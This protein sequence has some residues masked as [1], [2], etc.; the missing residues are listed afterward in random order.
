MELKRSPRFNRVFNRPSPWFFCFF[1]IQLLLFFLFTSLDH[2]E[3]SGFS[4][5]TEFFYFFFLQLQPCVSLS[6]FVELFGLFFMVCFGLV[7]F[8]QAF[9]NCTSSFTGVDQVLPGFTGFYLF[10][11]SFTRFYWVLLGFTGFYWVLPSFTGFYWVLPSFLRVL[12]EFT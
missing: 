6:C 8:D 11:L 10:W 4:C 1:F 9:A 7:G 12:P 3:W 2:R 5:C